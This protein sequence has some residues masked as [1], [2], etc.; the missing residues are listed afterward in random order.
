M[1]SDA[2]HAPSAAPA[3]GD[4]EADGQGQQA[5][6]PGSRVIVVGA[7]QAGLAMAH[8]LGR[9]G[10]E[11]LVLEEGG[12]VGDAWRIRWD[13]LRLFTPAAYD[14]LPGLRFPAAGAYFPTKDE[15]ADYLESY[16]AAFELPVQLGTRV[17]RVAREGDGFRVDAA[18]GQSWDAE[19][20]VI[21]TGGHQ[22]PHVPDVAGRIA[23]DVVQLHSSAYRQPTQLAPG[24]VLVVGAGNSGAE[25]A[26]EAATAGHRTWLAGRS[27]GHIPSR[28]FAFNG[29]VMMYLGRHLLTRDTPVG[30]RM[31]PR[32][33]AHG[34]PLINL[35]PADIAEA[36]VARVGRVVD[37]DD[38]L[39]AVEGGERIGPRTVVWAT[40]Y[41]PALGW[42]EP[43][44]VDDQGRIEQD[45]GIA[46]KVKG[47]YFVGQPFQTGFTSALIDGAGRDAARV[48]RHLVQ[49]LADRTAT[50]T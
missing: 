45:R 47:L 49:R 26:I 46:T 2:A 1:T 25:I 16:V 28:A 17:T 38:G 41:R 44:V 20:V 3:E 23:P 42:I 36:G 31:A 11:C 43:S 29:R 34:G 21:A 37:V 5:A 40:G 39:P 7:G 27:T 12:R 33:L 30:R 8:E 19:A 6:R 48:G 18:A 24:P 50:I 35:S 32:V 10:I 14:A 9:A 22:A 15:M 4:R 13:S